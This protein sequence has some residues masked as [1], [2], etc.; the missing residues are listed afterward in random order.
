M[1]DPGSTGNLSKDVI[2]VEWISGETMP[3]L[4]NPGVES[5]QLLFPGNSQ[6]RRV[7]VTQVRLAPNARQERHAHPASEQVWYALEGAGQ[8]LGEAY[9]QRR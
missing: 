8:L 6:S 4:C 2:A 1:R 5:K 7:T 9:A 3:V